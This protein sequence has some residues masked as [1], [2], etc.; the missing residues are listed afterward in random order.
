MAMSCVILRPAIRTI[1]VA[2]LLSREGAS[3][4]GME[5]APTL[6]EGLSVLQHAYPEAKV[7]IFPSGGFILPIVEGER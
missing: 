3:A 5:Y 6:E 4:M 2:P 1:L 7:A